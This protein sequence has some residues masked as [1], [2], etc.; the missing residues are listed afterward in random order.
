MLKYQNLA[1]DKEYE[2]WKENPELIPLK[3]TYGGVEYRGFPFERKSEEICVEGTKETSTQIFDMGKNLYATLVLTHYFD[4]AATEFTVWF[5]NVGNEDSAVISDPRIEME[6]KGENY[7]IRGIMGDHVNQYETYERE[8]CGGEYFDCQNGRPSH[9][10]FPYFNLEHDNGGVMLAIGW[11][12]RW[13][14]MFCKEEYGARYIAKYAMG[15]CTYLKPKEKIRTPLFFIGNY[16]T[17]GEFYATNYWRSWFMKYNMPKADALGNDIKPFTTCTVAGDT[18]SP[19]RDGSISENKDTWKPS[20]KKLIEEKIQVDFRWFDA[21]WFASPAGTSESSAWEY[22]G[23]WEFD[24]NKWGK[25]GKYFA[26]SVDYCHENGIKTLMWLEPE[27]VTMI[28]ELEKKFGYKKE[29]ALPLFPDYYPFQ[30]L[31]IYNNIGNEEC[32]EWTKNRVIKALKENKVDLY[33][34][35]FNLNPAQAWASQDRKEGVN[36]W[37]IT[38]C[39]AVAAHYRLLKEIIE[40]TLSYGGCGFSDSCASGGGRNDLE[41]LRFAVP[42]L[43]SDAD[44]ATTA[45]RL[46]MS[47]S[48]NKWIPFNGATHLEKNQGL[49]CLQDGLCD[50]YTWR[51]SYLPIMNIFGG[52]FTQDENYDFDTLRFGLSEWNRLNKYLTKDFY[53]LTKWKKKTDRTGFTAHCYMDPD[54]NEGILLAFR[55]EDCEQ[56]E[57]VLSLPFVEKGE[58][59]ACTDEDNGNVFN[60]EN[61]ELKLYFDAPR[62]SKLLWI[63]KV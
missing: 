57:L 13:E 20:I 19:N 2:S 38:E 15:L 43:R 58:I 37:G 9:V 32:Y 7:L 1:N 46:S 44:R 12:G 60:L 29:W 10:F 59:Y 28:D 17:K 31:Y 36:R 16:Y 56:T 50:V 54:T 41:T 45:L 63:K 52:R 24:K 39:K 48:F 53:P 49:E 8:L 21:G 6:F 14:T 3:Y 61:G 55:M 22:V 51:A 42:F 40:T 18:G 62:T 26:E 5:E 11:A 27:R 4:Y 23:S 33:R 25:D 34:E 35:D 30:F 47:S